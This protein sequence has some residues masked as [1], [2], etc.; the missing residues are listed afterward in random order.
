MDSDHSVR[1]E[2]RWSNSPAL[3]AWDPRRDSV[4][5]RWQVG[6]WECPDSFAHKRLV[7][8]SVGQLEGQDQ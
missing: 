8:A 6:G 4:A 2:V 1:L 3:V 5:F 7:M